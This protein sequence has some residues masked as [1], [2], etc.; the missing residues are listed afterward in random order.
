M[1]ARIEYDQITHL[2][3]L[4]ILSH[5]IH[6]IMLSLLSTQ[7][8]SLGRLGQYGSDDNELSPVYLDVCKCGHSIPQ[9]GADETIIG[10]LDFLS[11]G[12]VA[13]R[14]DKL[15][16]VSTRTYLPSLSHL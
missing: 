1:V 3:L 7:I 5:Y 2:V 6:L 8:H 11:Q 9:H 14:F 4:D 15:L 16:Q 13:M 12:R 10:H